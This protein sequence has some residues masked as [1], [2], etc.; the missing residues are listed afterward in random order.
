[1]L[2][3]EIMEAAEPAAG[4]PVV[5]LM[6]GRGA[7][8]SDLVGLRSWFPGNV[9]LVLPRAPHPGATWGYGPGW[10]WYR[11]EGGDRPE[12]ESY[13]SAQAELESL[14]EELPERLGREVGP[15]VVGGFSQGGT[16]GLGYALRRPGS[17]AGVLNL[18]GFLPDH[19]EV[20]ATP[21]TAGDLPVFWG[22]GT[23][24]PAV[25]FSLARRGRS[26]LRKAGAAL[27]SRD[28]A[29]GHGI[30]PREVEDAV[31]WLEG[32]LG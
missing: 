19:P 14:I 16:M 6:H 22:H 23:A 21:E 10:A 4:R 17:V 20:R 27:E 26:K 1:M 18:S 12:P 28:Y 29:M 2:E 5:V 31:A 13:R 8:P 9:G 15:V 11:Y 24:D 32:V 25:P 30:L 3:L 7:D